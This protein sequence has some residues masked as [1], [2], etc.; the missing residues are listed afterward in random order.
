MSKETNI[1]SDD[2]VYLHHRENGLVFCSY[3]G[4]TGNMI[5]FDHSVVENDYEIIPL[6]LLLDDVCNVK[7]KK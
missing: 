5:D 1:Q 7:E 4:S 3:Y 6:K 2:C